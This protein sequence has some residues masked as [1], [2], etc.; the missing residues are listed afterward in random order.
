LRRNKG[1]LTHRRI[2]SSQVL[3]PS[4][5]RRS[6]LYKEWTTK[7]RR[8]PRRM[9]VLGFIPGFKRS[10]SDEVSDRPASSRRV[11]APPWCFL[12]PWWC[13]RLSYEVRLG[14]SIHAAQ[15][16]RHDAHHLDGEERGL[17]NQIREARLVD[18]HQPAV[19]FGDCRG[20]ARIAIDQRQ[21]LV[22]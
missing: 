9:E 12:V 5:T 20:A 6:A 7:T 10:L 19:G 3:H 11:L 22:L 14:L 1:R 15:A 16:S 13:T 8:T 2:R 21:V 17:L 18:R 4:S